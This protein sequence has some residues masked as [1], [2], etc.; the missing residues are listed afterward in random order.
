MLDIYRSGRSSIE[1][2]M[3]VNA[4]VNEGQVAEVVKSSIESFIM[5]LQQ[6]DAFPRGI[7]ETDLR[8]ADVTFHTSDQTTNKITAG[9]RDNEIAVVL[10][11]D[12]EKIIIEAVY[13]MEE[14]PHRDQ[15]F[16][17]QKRRSGKR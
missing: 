8:Q 14:W 11:D 9:I 6:K 15:W 5:I 3:R 17:D 10:T 12:M 2:E 16:P 7:T 4:M 13:Q 1:T